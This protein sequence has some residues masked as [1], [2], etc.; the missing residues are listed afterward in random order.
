[1]WLKWCKFRED[2]INSFVGEVYQLVRELK[3][4]IWLSAACYPDIY[5]TPTVNFQNFRNWLENG[6]IDEI[7]SMSYGT[8]VEYSVGNAAD[9][10]KAVGNDAFYSTGL[11]V[12]GTTERD[13]L[14]RQISGCY[15]VGANGTNL[16]SWGSLIIHEQEYES[17]LA[18]T[19]FRS[20]SVQT[21]KLNE[22]I[23]AASEQLISKLKM[24]IRSSRRTAKR[25]MSLSYPSLKRSMIMLRI[26]TAIRLRQSMNTAKRP[27]PSLKHC[28]S[29]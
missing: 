12:F 28:A 22:T 25:F 4:E 26:L 24:F 8:S 9:F 15:D 14:L 2:I 16:F 20:P 3:P 29:P 23:R 11:S 18:K 13:I 19:V 1:M 7:F 17:A 5:G 21:Y 6:W 10:V 27:S